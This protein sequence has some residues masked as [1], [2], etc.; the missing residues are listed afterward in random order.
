MSSAGSR[1]PPSVA[2]LGYGGLL[3][4]ALT[5]LGTLADPARRELW[6]SALLAYGAVILS[7]VGAL[8][9]AFAM[10]ANDERQARPLYVWSVVPALA[11]W[12]ALLLPLLL[13]RGAVPAALLL[14]LA[15]IAHYVQDQRLARRH[16]L[17]GWYLPLRLRLSS[18]A[19]LCLAAIPYVAA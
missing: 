10:N 16:P 11:G 12:L 15:F 14:I 8:H 2:W 6:Q 1:L 13:A 7:F 5:A 18:V 17:P 19:C 4:F 9:W 3:P